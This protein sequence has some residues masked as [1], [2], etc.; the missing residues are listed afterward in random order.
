MVGFLVKILLW[1]VPTLGTALANAIVAAAI[2]IGQEEVAIM[3]PVIRGYITEADDVTK[4][5]E[6]KTGPQ[7]F[8]WVFEQS[9][10]AFPSANEKAIGTLINVIVQ[11]AE[12]ILAA[13]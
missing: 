4:H 3:L 1:V 8:V 13:L 5:P 7:K 10:A 12:L 11:E 2:G 6:L 9:V